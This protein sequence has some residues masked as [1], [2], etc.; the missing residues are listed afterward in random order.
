MMT[1]QLVVLAVVA[2]LVS[3]PAAAEHERDHQT[4]F[5]KENIGKAVGAAAGALL[6]TQIGSGR[7]KLAAV[8]IG[9]LAGY[10][11]GGNVG[12]YLTERDQA[13]IAYAT[14]Q[15]L[16]TDQPQTWRNP[17]TGVSTRVS[18]RDA[19]D[20]GQQ[21][22]L[23]ALGQAPV[24]ELINGF[25]IADANINVRGGP[26]TE[27]VILYRLAQGERVPVV[28]RV[29]D[30]E[31]L[32]IAENGAGNGFVYGPLFT[33]SDESANAIRDAMYSGESFATYEVESRECRL[34]SQEVVLPDDT[35]RTH[36]FKACRQSDGT[37]M[38]V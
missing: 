18:V 26:S 25:Y 13:G 35:T 2:G 15:A 20:A 27:H 36:E 6:G 16:E 10:W 17:D 12:R 34:I 28:G 14:H 33:P 23:A 11:V 4:P 37:W 19:G 9:T 29:A 38:E 7:G 8:A 3:G 31:W 30:S 1:R 24:L 32:M 5:T 21:S 22:G